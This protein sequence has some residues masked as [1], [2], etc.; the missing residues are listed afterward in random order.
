[1]IYMQGGMLITGFTSRIRGTLLGGLLPLDR[2]RFMPEIMAGIVMAA[3]FIPEVMGYAKI[4]GMPIITGIYT[5]LIPMVVFA[6]FCSS[7]HLIVGADSAT[8]AIMFGILVTAAVPGSRLYLSMAFY[9]AI[10]CGLFLLIARL[11]GL[12]FI[13]DFLSRTALV[14]FLTGV[15]VQVAISQLGGMFGLTT[16]GIG[17]FPKI[18]SFI[19][20]LPQTSLTTLMVSI[21]VVASI[22]I[23]RRI[24]PKIPGALIAVGGTIMASY[25]FDFTRIGVSVVGT[26]PNGIPTISIPTFSALDYYALFT[27]AGA[28]FIVII[29]QSAATSRAYSVKFSDELDEDKD[30]L[31]LG[32]SNIMAG[33]TGSFVVNGSP[34]KTQVAV[35]SGARSQLA[36]LIA[37]AVVL[38]VVLFFTKPLSIL[39]NAT[40]ASI[41]FLIGLEMVDIKGLKDIYYEVPAEFYLA[42]ITLITVVVI[43]VLWGILVAVIISLILHLSHSYRPNNSILIRNE[44]GEWAFVPV[45]LGAYTEKG[46]IVYRFNR[47]LYYANAEKLM[48]EVINLVKSS[49]YPVYWLVLDS[50]GFT[51]ID[52][53]SVQMLKEL[54][55][56]L[57]KLNVLLVMTTVFPS[58]RM[59]F[60]RSGF[61]KVLG[62]ENLYRGVNDAIKA[63]ERRK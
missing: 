54:K 30:I 8:A 51:G 49:D 10:L 62:E 14:G 12:G 1:M 27:A 55:I 57:D 45:I 21:L 36:T 47:D 40:L 16:T 3:I 46:L 31:G 15:G 33:L 6:I 59:Q 29:A 20:N 24:D 58:L 35:E 56:R 2:S 53:T 61:I 39:P 4:A 23:F 7:R 25:I 18:L 11:L 32:I 38:L 28:C 52:Y 9:V 42:L 17:A 60:E 26:V 34:T 50:G 22:I 44:R 43:G 48:K 13:G 41:V 5:I 63:F 19:S 37:A